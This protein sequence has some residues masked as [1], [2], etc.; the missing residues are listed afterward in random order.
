MIKDAS[1]I[2]EVVVALENKV[3]ALAN[4][5]K[6]LADKDINIAA[7]AGYSENGNAKIM[8]VTDDNLRAVEALQKGG[9]KTVK[10]SEA[11]LVDLINKTGALKNLTAKLA[12][13]G[14][15]IKYIYGSQCTGTCPGRLILSTTNNEKTF[16]IL[17]G[18]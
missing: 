18:K 13:E 9:Y 5:S 3:G 17:K 16:I 12:S 7:V 6:I 11:V 15:S 8:L 2:K 4:I 14:V 1:L 10:E